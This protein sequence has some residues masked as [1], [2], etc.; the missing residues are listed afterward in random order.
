MRKIK[1]RAWFERSE[2]MIEP[3]TIQEMIHQKIN[4]IS[5]DD[6]YKNI[7]FMQ[8]TGFKD[9]NGVEVYEG[10][11]VKLKYP[12]DRRY[13]VEAKVVNGEH[14][15]AMILKFED[16]LTSEEYPLYKITANFNLE[17]VGN[18]YQNKEL[19]NEW[20]DINS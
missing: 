20:I 1:F 9:K 10:D 15:S 17:V 6:L 2:R 8:Y 14:I 7:H 5:L 12:R 16:S 19:L 13:R 11:I 4:T 18:I 3:M